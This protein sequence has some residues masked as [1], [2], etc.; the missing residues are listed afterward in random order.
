MAALNASRG[1]TFIIASHDP[2]VIE[3]ARRRIRM[4]DGQI[5]ADES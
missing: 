5:E 3:F 1:T 4:R 2:R